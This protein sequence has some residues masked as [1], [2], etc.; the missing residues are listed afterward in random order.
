MKSSKSM[1]T[2]ITEIAQRHGCDLSYDQ[3]ELRLD[4]VNFDRLVI[5]RVGPNQISVA[6]YF[7]QAGDLVA[8]PKIVFFTGDPAGWMP[9]AISQVMTGRR[10]VAWLTDDGTTID[11]VQP[12][13]QA[14]V[15][16]FANIWAKN[17]RAQRWLQ[18]GVLTE[19]VTRPTEPPA[20]EL[21]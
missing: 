10:A 16:H 21:G 3:A 13:A 18:D 6:H 11:R 7:E 8:D 9:I 15:A 5:A 12:E 19:L 20:D 1:Q 14:D 2:I 4:M 17:I